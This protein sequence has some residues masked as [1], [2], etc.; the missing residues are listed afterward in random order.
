MFPPRQY[1]GTRLTSLE[2]ERHFARIFAV[3]CFAVDGFFR[4]PEN[5]KQKAGMKAGLPQLTVENVQ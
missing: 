3:D 5:A 4:E 2:P 1:H